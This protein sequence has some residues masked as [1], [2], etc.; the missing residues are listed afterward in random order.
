VLTV[1]ARTALMVPFNLKLPE[2]VTR[3]PRYIFEPSDDMARSGLL[4][5]K[6]A[7]MAADLHAIQFRLINASE[8]AVQ[9]PNGVAIANASRVWDP[10]R[11]LPINDTV[12]KVNKHVKRIAAITL[13]NFKAASDK[14]RYVAVQVV[15]VRLDDAACILNKKYGWKGLR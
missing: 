7:V 14:I 2:K 5:E 4:M 11:D 10:G 13:K 12:R 15:E 9:L 3:A 8:V 6:I 1:P